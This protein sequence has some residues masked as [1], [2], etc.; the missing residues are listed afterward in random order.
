MTA[1]LLPNGKQAYHAAS[2]VPLVGGK[3]YTYAAGTSTL[4]TTWS[5]AAQ[6]AANAN[7][8]IL[9]SRGE[10]AIFW[11]GS[12][13]VTLKDSL[14]SLIWTKDN[15][16]TNASISG[17]PVLTRTELADITGQANNESRYLLEAGRE[18]LFKFSTANLSALVT[19]D[20]RQG[21]YVAPSSATTGASGAWVRQRES[22]YLHID[23]FGAVGDG[24]TDD[25]TA[26]VGMRTLGCALATG[27]ASGLRAGPEI[28]LGAK[29]YYLASSFDCKGFTAKWTGAGAGYDYWTNTGTT[30]IKMASGATWYF[31]AAN[32]E[33]NTTGSTIAFSCAGST[34]TNITWQGPG[35]AV[36]AARIASMRATV[37]LF[38]CRFIDGGSHGLAIYGTIGGGTTAEGNVNQWGLYNCAFSLNGGSGLYTNGADANAGVCIGATFNF[39][40]R[41]GTEE[42]SFLGNDY[43]GCHWNGNTLGHL[44]GT[45]PNNS[46]K[47]F[48]YYESGYPLSV[49]SPRSI[50]S[51]T[52]ST[53]QVTGASLLAN[54][55]T[56]SGA[57]VLS[58]NGFQ[59]QK[60]GATKNYN[61]VT[62]AE[63]DTQP[64][65]KATYTDFNAGA[66]NVYQGFM[67]G[68]QRY[69]WGLN[70]N[71]VEL[72]N[73]NGASGGTGALTY[74]LATSPA[75]TMGMTGFALGSLTSPDGRRIWTD[76]AAPT[77]GEHARGEIVFD[78][79]PA[80]SGKIG[81][82]CVTG[83]TP[84][85]WKQ[86]GV[87]DA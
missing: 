18:G 49:I 19:A 13:K 31:Q 73:V 59:I 22:G 58:A 34:F 15:I 69:I 82:V 43:Y 21:I 42:E 61:N 70:Y 3:V 24:A 46:S 2:G 14:D 65:V 79:A 83:G 66:T 80:A 74:G 53:N 30:T 29:T 45:N 25:T 60:A 23:W 50:A 27:A 56:G 81:W 71:A 12:Y 84:G 32:T 41:Y 64:G 52:N 26:F 48:G 8:V 11:S 55:A 40:A 78:R 20:T 68:V 36:G 62:G 47:F 9:D 77:T 67:P 76:T 28:R 75:F 7:P 86:W 54:D 6:T 35:K 72:L 33:G 63:P 87:I 4:K 57:G 85:T 16:N 44:H 17:G 1:I 10:A 39:N 51:G 5:D 37:A 38:N